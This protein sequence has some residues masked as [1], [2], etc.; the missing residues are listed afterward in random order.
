VTWIC[1]VLLAALVV[2][3]IIDGGWPL[4]F[5]LAGV[6]SERRLQTRADAFKGKKLAAF[7]A[8]S[9]VVMIA[10]AMVTRFV[11]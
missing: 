7:M 3:A 11:L 5:I 1:R 6:L 2:L 9:A 10:V 4:A 8:G